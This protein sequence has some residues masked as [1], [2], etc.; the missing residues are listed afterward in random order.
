MNGEAPAHDVVFVGTGFDSRVALLSRGGLERDRP[1]PLRGAGPSVR[2]GHPL[3]PYVHDGLVDNARAGALYRK[4]RIGLNLYRG[5]GRARRRRA[6]TPGPTSW[7]RTGCSPW[8]SPGPSRRSAWAAP[9]PPSPPPGS[10]RS[11]SAPTWPTPGA[12]AARPR[13]LPALVAEDTYHHRA[14]QL[15][16]HLK[17]SRKETRNVPIYHGRDGAIYISTTR[18][19]DR[20]RTCS[21]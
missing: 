20:R 3:R 11:A 5:H 14:A 12:G 19:E 10:W 13:R 8:P 17:L 6:S 16:A 1:G 2:E 15:V 21:P 9:S 4:A 18:H 7:R